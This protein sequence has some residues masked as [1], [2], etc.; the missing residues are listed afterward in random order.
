MAQTGKKV[1]IIE[2]SDK[3][4]ADMEETTM[5]ALNYKV[6]DGNVQVLTSMKINEITEEGV[7]ITD[8]DGQR[9]LH[10]ADSVLLALGLGP[11]SVH[12]AGEAMDKSMQTCTI[13]DANGFRGIRDA[14]SDGHVAACRL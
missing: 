5:D 2:E 6:A 12:P 3:F 7:V 10:A 14:I 4:G 8:R 1:T 13:G 9:A 11:S